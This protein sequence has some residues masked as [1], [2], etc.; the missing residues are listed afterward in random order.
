MWIRIKRMMMM[1]M[2]IIIIIIIIII[3]KYDQQ[4][5]TKWAF[6]Q[7][8]DI[9]TLEKITIATVKSKNCAFCR[10]NSLVKMV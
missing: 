5:N 2:M 9:F 7:K 6:E 8:H 4:W 10:K 1:M 3:I